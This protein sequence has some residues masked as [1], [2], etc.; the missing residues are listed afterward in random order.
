MN[1]VKN[2]ISVDPLDALIVGGV[3]ITRTANEYDA[4]YSEDP[5]K[6]IHDIHIRYQLWDRNIQNYLNGKN[7]KFSDI[8]YL[9]EGDGIPRMFGGEE[10]G[11]AKS[12]RYQTLLKDIRIVTSRK[13]NFLRGLKGKSGEYEDT[14]VHRKIKLDSQ[15]IEF[16]DK[17]AIIKIG[18]FLI[19]LPPHKN[20]YD[21]CRVMWKYQIR[22][23]VDWSE[24]YEEMTNQDPDNKNKNE[25][26]VRDAMYS[27][28]KRVR[29]KANTGDDLF[30]W[31][32]KCIKRLF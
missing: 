23:P 27:A 26:M 18:N 10:Y 13:L 14:D 8:S 30:N 21:F 16:D 25:R 29:A 28:N 7:K 17:K 15:K 12:D 22:E 4:I 31:S 3:N 24:I 9:Y 1:T 19:E 32:N 6:F 11:D 5:V 2:K 20:E